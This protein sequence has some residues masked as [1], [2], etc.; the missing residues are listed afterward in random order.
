MGEHEELAVLDRAQHTLADLERR[1][2]VGDRIRRLVGFGV[3]RVNIDGVSVC[4][5]R[6]RTIPS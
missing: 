1:E 6:R 4:G 3:E 2:P 5:M